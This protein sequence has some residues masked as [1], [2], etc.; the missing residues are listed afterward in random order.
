MVFVS[1]RVHS[2]FAF[3]DDRVFH[4]RMIRT[5]G[6]GA[7]RL[8]RAVHYSHK[9]EDGSMEGGLMRLRVRGAEEPLQEERPCWEEYP[10]S[11]R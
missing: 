5:P 10:R 6:R 4:S 7:A 3:I 2:W 11:A 9:R 8:G 1:I